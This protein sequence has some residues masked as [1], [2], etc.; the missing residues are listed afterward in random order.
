[1][2][3]V[4]QIIT[5][6]STAYCLGGTMANGERVHAG[7]VASEMYPIGTHILVN[8]SPTGRR[9]WVVRD[10]TDGRTRLDFWVPS[11]WSA[12]QWGRRAVRVRRR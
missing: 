4:K 7:S 10:H 2:L 11:C 5:I 3:L 12:R 9:H 1:M 6:F 8:R